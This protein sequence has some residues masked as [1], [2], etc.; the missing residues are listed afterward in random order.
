[1]C[2]IVAYNGKNHAVDFLVAGISQLEYRGYDSVGLAVSS[3]HNLAVFKEKG[4]VKDLRNRY[5]NLDSVMGHRGLAHTR[6]AT[7]GIPST[8]NAHP[9][10]VGKVTLVHNG[11]IE[12]Y[13]ELKENELKDGGASLQSETDSEVVCA[14][15]NQVYAASH[16][17]LKALQYVATRIHGTYAFVVMFEGDDALYV[18]RL[19]SPLL[20]GIGDDELFVAS[21]MSPLMDK[22]RRYVLL[23]EGEVG[24]VGRTDLVLYD[25]ESLREK[26]LQIHEATW[27]QTSASL[28]DFDHYMLKEIHEQPEILMANYMRYTDHGTVTFNHALA[29]DFFENVSRIHILACGTAYH[30]GLMGKGWIESIAKVPVEVH[31]ASEFRYGDPL[32]GANDCCIFISQSGETADLVACLKYVKAKGLKTLGIVNVEG[33]S[34]ARDVDALLLTH[35]GLEKS[36]ASTKAYTAQLFVL[37]LVAHFLNGSKVAD[38]EIHALYNAMQTLIADHPAIKPIAQQFVDVNNAFYLG[39]GLDSYLALEAS[40]KL[41]EITYIHAESYPAGELKHGSIALI[42]ESVLTVGI[43]LQSSVKEKTL[44]NLQEVKSRMGRVFLVTDSLEN[45]DESVSDAAYVVPHV[46]DALAALVGIIP[47]Q[48]FAYEICV[49]R[50]FDVDYPRNLAKSVTVE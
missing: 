50:G 35:A 47:L 24:V 43:A 6:W 23:E 28:G 15:I 37:Y 11:I 41:K 46:S 36:V 45:V 9:H 19:S 44:S 2:G 22:T 14:L 10:T 29:A 21:D 49:Q 42:D 5:Q 40:L 4:R 25:L 7:H 33:S 27:D 31:V 34:I 16:D 38:R 48:L 26:P 13:Q 12:N 18:L 17:P 32:L 20:V 39:R 1:M 8:H 30:A 3:D